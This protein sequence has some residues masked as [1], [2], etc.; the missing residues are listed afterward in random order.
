[1]I[2]YKGY[3]I[4]PHKSVPT[5]YIIVADGKGGSIPSVMEGVFTS[6]T[7]A[8]ET[9]DRYKKEPENDKKVSKS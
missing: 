7:I 1:V 3:Q 5:V 9:I 6:P 8:K 2:I 4:K